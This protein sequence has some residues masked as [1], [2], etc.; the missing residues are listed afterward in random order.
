MNKVHF[1]LILLVTPP[2]RKQPTDI[3][4]YV[5]AFAALFSRG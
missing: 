1:A 4:P 2:A 5:N 3:N